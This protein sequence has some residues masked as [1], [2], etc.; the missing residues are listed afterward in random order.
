MFGGCTSLISMNLTNFNT[1]NLENINN[2][3]YGCS[4]I[5]SVDLSNWNIQNLKHMKYI[6]SRCPKIKFLD[7][8]SFNNNEFYQNLLK[9]IPNNVTLKVHK[10]FIEKIRIFNKTKNLI[11][12]YE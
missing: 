6:F 11:V 8:S 7:V 5:I 3:F 4:S 9:E 12:L 2:L 10:D 1:S